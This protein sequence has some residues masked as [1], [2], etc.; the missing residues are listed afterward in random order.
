MSWVIERTFASGTVMYYVEGD[1]AP[2]WSLSAECATQFAT[3]REA[4]D[5]NALL[6]WTERDFVR[7]SERA[8]HG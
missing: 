7:P 3:W 6:P 1:H 8:R 2:T 4:E 5:A